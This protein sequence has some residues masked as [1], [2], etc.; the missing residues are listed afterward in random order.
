MVIG[1]VVYRYERAEKRECSVGGGSRTFC[2]IIKS[3]TKKTLIMFILV[4]ALLGL[5]TGRVS[6]RNAMGSGLL[7]PLKLEDRIGTIKNKTN[8]EVDRRVTS[9]NTVITRINAMKRLSDSD[10]AGFVA[11]AN[12][13]LTSLEALKKQTAAET[14]AD[15]LKTDRMSIYN[16]YQIYMLF[17]PRMNIMAGADRIMEIVNRSTGLMPAVQ[18]RIIKLQSA[19]KDVNALNTVLTDLQSK[20]ADA[21]TQ[22][23]NTIDMVSGLKP[24]QGDTATIRNNNAA[25]KSAREMIR[26]ATSNLIAARIDIRAIR[27]K[28]SFWGFS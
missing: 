22:A 17:V 26:V 14:E 8:Q 9:I 2:G 6:A 25:L 5:Y 28:L 16:S 11:Q 21:K 10:K 1:G 20:L 13:M 18:T 3:M 12:Q 23:Q 19:G 27:F 4:I 7:R 15:S 24:D